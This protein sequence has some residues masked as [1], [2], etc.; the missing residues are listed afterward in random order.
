MCVQKV[1][2][3]HGSLDLLKDYRRTIP[4]IKLKIFLACCAAVVV[5]TI[6]YAN[7]EGG[8]VTAGNATITSS[9]ANTVQ[10]QQS[11]DKA[12]IDWRSFNIAA[13]E[14]IQFQ[15]PSS[16]S[17]TL[18]R[19]DPGNGVS[20]I[21]GSL[22]ANGNVWLVNP[23]GIIFGSTAR[24]DVGGL[25]ATTANINTADFMAGNYHFVQSP[26]WNGAVI[27]E[28]LITIADAGLAGL[29][30]P[31]VENHGVIR[32][33]LGT[34]LLAAT[35]EY[36]I[37][38]Y[39]DQLIQFGL[40]AKV[41]RP[42]VAQ[43]GR[44]LKNG[45]NNTGKI[46]A[47]GGKILVTAK[48]ADDVL[49]HA[50]NMHGY[51]S[52]NSAMHQNGEIILTAGEGSIKVTGKIYAKNN[53][54]SQPGGTVKILGSK[55][56]ISDKAKI[57]V[58]GKNGGGTILI[59][60]NAHGIGPEQNAKY[61]FIGTDA[62]LI[63]NAIQNGNGGRVIVWSDLG[64]YFYGNIQAKG[65]LYAGNGGFVETSGKEYLNVQGSVNASAK[66]GLAGEWLLDPA[67]V[68]IS[69][70]VTTNGSFNGGSPNTFT[71]TAD[72]AIANVNTIQTSLNGGTSVTILTS[73]NGTQNG[74][75]TVSNAISKTAGGAATL[76]LT[77][78]NTGTI[79]VN[80]SITS[81]T[82][83]LSVVLNGANTININSAITTNG[84]SF[85]STSLADTTIGAAL[86]TG[87]GTVGINVNTGG[88]GANNFTLASGGSI[89]TTN[90][91]TSAVAINVNAAGGGTGGAALAGNISTG[92]GGR[93]TIATNTG[94]NT[95]GG[96]I[97]QTAGSLSTGTGSIFLA[98]PT[99][100]SNGIGSSGSSIATTTTGSLNLTA[101][102]GGVFV[103]NTGSVT[104]Q[105][106]TLASNSALSV[107]SS[108]TLT[109]PAT[110][111][112]T[113]TGDLTLRSNG[114][115]LTT[116]GALTTTNGN[117]TLVG[118]TGLTLSHALQTGSGNMSFSTT[119]SG[120]VTQNSGGTI[121]LTSGNLSMSARDALSLAATVDLGSGTGI[122]SSN[123]DGAG[124]STFSMGAGSSITTTNTGASAVQINANTSGGGTGAAGLR[125]ITTG[126]G[127]TIAVSSF[128]ADITQ[129]AATLLDVGIGTVSL[130]TNQ[131]AGLNIGA[132]GTNVL[133]SAG[134]LSATSGASGTFITNSGVG[135]LALGTLG[136]TGAFT[137]TSTSSSS[138]TQTAPAIVTG[139]TT[140]IA[141]A[142]QNITLNNAGNDFGTLAITSGNNVTL[143]DT[144][145]LI[146]G[147]STISGDLNVTTNGALT[148]SAAISINGVGKTATFA[149]GALNNITLNTSTNDFTNLIITSGNDVNMRDANT[150]VLGASTI[151]GN[152][153]LTTA[154]TMTQTG[155]LSVN[156]VGKVTTLVA[157]AGNNITLNDAGNDFATMVITSGNNVNLQDVNA[158]QF[159]AAT[160]TV[161]GTLD[162]TTAGNISQL[163]GTLAVTGTTTLNAGSANDITLNNS[164]NN[165]TTL[166]IGNANNTTL[167]DTNAIIIGATNILGTY[168]LIAGGSV[169]QSAALTAPIVVI[170]TLNN[171]ASAITLSN[172]SNE[173]NSI[174]LRTR[175]AADLAN[176]AAAITYR[177]ATGFDVS[178]ISTGSTISL[179]A[180]G[181]ITDS[182]TMTGTT[183]TTSTAGGIALDFGH[184]VTV[185][186][187]TNITSGD[188]QLLNTA[189]LSI[190]G[191]SQA[192]GG[193]VSINNTGTTAVTG[194]VNTGTGNL[195]LTSTGAV[196][197]TAA[198]T[199]PSL[200][201]KTLNDAGAAITLANA[202]NEA[203]TID[204]RTRNAADTANAAGAISYRD[205]TGVD[206]AAANSTSIITL[207]AGDILSQ[208]GSM[209]GTTLT[210]KTLLTAGAAINLT[211]AS[212]EFTTVDLRARNTGD[213]ANAAGAINYTDATGFAVA[214]ANT[215][216]TINLIGGDVL[217]QT[218]AMAG[219]TLTAKTLNNLGAAITL[220]NSGNSLT[221]INLQTRNAADT[222]TVAAAINY[223]D[224]N[225]IDIAN[226]STGS[227][228]TLTA[229]GAITQSGAITGSSLAA[230]TVLNGGAAITLNNVGN[231]LT[232][233][234]IRTRN[235]ADSANAAGAI[236][237]TGAAGFDVSTIAT[238]STISLTSPGIITDSGAI[239]G[240]TLTTSTDGGIALDFGHTV[241]GFNATN[242]TSGDVQLRNT[243]ALSITGISQAGG[244]NVS[245]NNTGTTAVTGAVNTGTGSLSLASTG[246]VT[247]TAAIT[248]P[249]LTVKTLND[250]GA[251]I[252]LANAGNEVISV[253]LRARNAADTANDTGAISYRDAT[254]FDVLAANS[255][256]TITLTSGGIISQS[257][258]MTGTTLTAKTLLD[259]GAAINLTNGSNEFATI[260]L[261]ARNTADGANA[262]GA[263]NYTDVSGFAVAAANTTDDVALISSG[264]ITQTGS[265]TGIN[266]TVKTLNDLGSAITLNNSGNSLTTVNLQTRNAADT[267][268]VAAA[269]NYRDTNAIDIANIST[270]SSVTLTAGGAIT[271]SGAITS[272]SLAA[273]TVLNGGAAITLNNVG[274][275]LTSIDIRTRNTADSANAAGAI[276]YTGA[277]GFDVSTIATTSTISLTSP[278]IIT[279]SGAITGTTLTTST[280]GGIA[281]DFG[282]TVTGFNATNI[283]S[284]DV[285]LRNTA[286]LS[287]TGIS[288]AGGGNVS[289]N[290]TGTTAVTG[291]VNTGTGSLSLTS[292]GAVTQAAAI[293]TPILTVKTLNNA[294]A[295]ITLTNSGNEVN[296]IDLRARNAA[297][298]A[299][300]TGAISYRDATGFD[301]LAAN[302][303]STIT[304]TSGGIISQ[305]GSMTGTTLT[306]KTL[307]NSGAAINLTNASN[308]FTTIDLRARN[309]A[310]TANVAGAL[311]Y[312]D[313]T[314]YAVA[315]A[316]TLG[317]VTLTA[318]A[319]ITQT[320]AMTGS[321]L[322]VKTL[323]DTGSAITLNNAGNDFSTIDIRVRNAANTNNA[324]AALSYRDANAIDIVNL[325]SASS[326]TLIGG[327]ITES[328]VIDAPTL[329]VTA[330]GGATLNGT[331]TISTLTATNNTSGNL[332]LVNTA[333]PLTISS[334]TQNSTGN[335]SITNTGA[336]TASGNITANGGNINLTTSQ[337]DS[338]AKVL[339]V[340]GNITSSGGNISLNAA[341][342]TG[343]VTALNVNGIL[344]TTGGSG[345]GTLIT[346]GGV[347]LNAT[348]VLG[349]GNITLQGNG[350]DLTLGSLSFTTPIGFEVTRYIIISGPITSSGAGSNLSFIGDAGHSG[351]GGVLITGSGSINS[352]GNVTLQ[353]SN[354]SGAPGANTSA[355]VEIQSGA[356]VQAAGNI[357]VLGDVGNQNIVLNGSLQST[358]AGA[359]ITITPV[360]SGATQLNTTI[361]A[362]NGSINFNN[363]VLISG[364]TT[365]NSGSGNVTFG[366]S[367]TT[368]GGTLTL[369]SLPNASGTFLFNGNVTLDNL[370]TTAQPYQVV[371]QGANNTFSNAI[372]FNNTGGVTL[373]GGNSTFNLGNSYS[374]TASVTKLNGI[375]NLN[376]QLFS[377]SSL[378][379]VGNSTINN[380][381]ANL[382]L[383]TING[384]YNLTLNVGSQNDIYINSNIGSAA[385]I[386]NLIL[387]SARNVTNNASVFANGFQQV[388]GNLLSLGN[389]FTVFGNANISG[390]QVIGVINA[391]SL[392]LNVNLANLT[393]SIGGSSGRG[394][395][396]RINLSGPIMPNTHFFDGID[397]LTSI[398][399]PVIITPAFTNNYD[400][401]VSPSY[402][403][404][405]STLDLFHN[406]T[407]KPKYNAKTGCA[408]VG[409]SIEICMAD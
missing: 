13:H 184:T 339:T 242:I 287:I 240:T 31:G 52:A 100:S 306:A 7:P 131:A 227:S 208:S 104:L 243:A 148:Q 134:A 143:Q 314:G 241:T 200:T 329:A 44:E 268:T 103:S 254:G 362:N 219:T 202:G 367:V 225:A 342:P 249:I 305:S 109:L 182:G 289:I 324:A 20:S 205:A 10:I 32:A 140:I 102:T 133:I 136:S 183:L 106:P 186:N 128:G 234:D 158:F 120:N 373:G 91:G 256:S 264:A 290:N 304:L 226:I 224:T 259:G 300:D 276:S 377:V 222:S 406:A 21:L 331:N 378:E 172:A 317:N 166:A 283:T 118:S 294:G 197:Q 389:N 51:V 393:G 170:K 73:P 153:T 350:L 93:I 207:T 196:T 303:A 397:M 96:S 171:T 321:T 232:S 237:Y 53:V 108:G 347:A 282:H 68:T 70:A 245:I 408:K 71:T 189:A 337:T 181:V 4:N 79:N 398:V 84:G 117:L 269:I 288:Q 86:S 66:H 385:K 60:G 370:I 318:G 99:A 11:S 323:N 213:S 28:G 221:T 392:N 348:P 391:G 394:A 116:A 29:V 138:I 144:N 253:D 366:N 387:N 159:G 132:A 315:A 22:T 187:A 151:S 190:T 201:V 248:T 203:T 263:L 1:R 75:I 379:L 372:T 179:T 204:L 333:A 176:T 381:G 89:A 327:V 312:T 168:N 302:S 199:T 139:T 78:A 33:N 344:N 386:N 216:S 403:S 62:S 407:S 98:V 285:Q 162:L 18:N 130:S 301:V 8:Q 217:T 129:T 46:I 311:S 271:Q 273:K 293:T 160:S 384:T 125:S 266:L 284:G 101:G 174:D 115:T 359:N 278:G 239:T 56:I 404:G 124:T 156:G 267:S 63:A 126:S 42:A 50:I 310:D 354:V 165:F 58:S 374:N 295:A 230:K 90:T 388:S 390:N 85:S 405:S 154:G 341:N 167:R 95:T 229:G 81:T 358:L 313:I 76:T 352:S 185:F 57:N 340:N 296:T 328:G 261:R 395:I 30:A 17:I 298:T 228:V 119:T 365:I 257:G 332:L 211:N 145:G 26:E 54:S 25:L 111:I 135:S 299:N 45:V 61:T 255:A 251:A 326:A 322:F 34:V 40:N 149:A 297:D 260:D 280:D 250:A 3:R 244:G 92:S 330:N 247:Q 338:T 218:G 286:A 169:T 14:K 48:T 157:G 49:D 355:A 214:A 105:A 6:G 400:T 212:N 274:N 399:S 83:A 246:A 23:A 223:R 292:T 38:F 41:N 97:T 215:T 236:S 80:Q 147:A 110:A 335:V 142:G 94:G 188:I 114:G 198:I 180:A 231:A 291:A 65:G 74:D 37:D 43:D 238:T 401:V 36:T 233:I 67:N 112:S 220:N 368:S 262:A 146:L 150:V 64:T 178:A 380:V 163:G 77:A 177:D 192:G 16:Q 258:S 12:V 87:A 88:S 155:S 123:T 72:D 279:D 363:P 319:A 252:T 275:A 193:N 320:G 15:Q 173:T 137:L 195:T 5:S 277:A 351:T 349:A 69:S 39:G 345:Q 2:T 175:N 24:V 281:L 356:T 336:L 402:T 343:L 364:A 357:S 152:F 206:V 55:V 127:G 161:S 396:T 316:N 191:I 194:A 376:N 59:G 270:G 210:A 369:Q 307:S 122:F 9:D 371:F 47:P 360:G 353:G 121:T 382:T 107:I 19:I 265:M 375:L 334:I 272:S 113:G 82:G 309:V 409:N 308:E 141:G 235:T 325:S 383:P 209:T 164:A 27:N 361:S 35:N 346:G